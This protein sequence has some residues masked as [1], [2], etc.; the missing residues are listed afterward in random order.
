[1][2]FVRLGYFCLDNKDTRM[3]AALLHKLASEE[4][5]AAPDPKS[6]FLVANRTVTLKEDAKKA[7]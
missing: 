5:L 1:M 3:D 4:A 2:Q 7:A 6:C